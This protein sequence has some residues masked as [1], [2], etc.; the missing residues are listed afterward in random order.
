[1][2]L[3]SGHIKFCVLIMAQQVMSNT[4]AEALARDGDS[5]TTETRRFVKMFNK[6]FDLLNVRSLNEA[7]HERNPNKEP[8]RSP[9]D[10]RLQVNN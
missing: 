7:I 5:R 10:S 3:F 6:F 8:F 1:M 4:V 9:S 2:T